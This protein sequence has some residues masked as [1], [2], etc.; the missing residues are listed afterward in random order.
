MDNRRDNNNM[1]NNL[2][3]ENLVK[4]TERAFCRSDWM[5][6]SRREC[7]TNDFM[8]PRMNSHRMF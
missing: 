6:R 4:I 5:L 3:Q 8:H 7:P 1:A 2:F